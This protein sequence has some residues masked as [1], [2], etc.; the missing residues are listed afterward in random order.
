MKSFST[1]TGGTAL[2]VSDSARVLLF[3]FGASPKW[4]ERKFGGT[5]GGK[6]CTGHT[7]CPPQWMFFSEG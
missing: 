4:K 3:I 6:N 2:A 1:A 5:E 7:P